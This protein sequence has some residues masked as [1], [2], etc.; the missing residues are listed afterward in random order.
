MYWCRFWK[1]EHR[2]KQYSCCFLQ[3]LCWQAR[4]Q[5]CRSF[6]SNTARPKLWYVGV[7]GTADN[8]LPSTL[9][10][11]QLEQGIL[12]L[13]DP[14]VTSCFPSFLIGQK[15]PL[16]DQFCDVFGIVSGYLISWAPP[17]C[18]TLSKHLFLSIM[19]FS[20]WNTRIVSVFFSEC[21]MIECWEMYP[22]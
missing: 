1:V 10:Q 11:T 14:V 2:W 20:H 9:P 4:L 18:P 19:S 8:I 16:A 15:E 6:C 5:R 7:E 13:M 22:S 17:A 3:F 21:K 12:K